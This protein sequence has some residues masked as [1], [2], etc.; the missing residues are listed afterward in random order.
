MKESAGNYGISSSNVELIEGR[1]LVC[2]GGPGK[3]SGEPL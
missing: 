3:T 1:G 2:L